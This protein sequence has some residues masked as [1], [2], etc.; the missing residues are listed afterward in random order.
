M[1]SSMSDTTRI[2]DFD[3]HYY[4]SED[5]FTRH[6]DK[7]LRSRG[8]RWAEVDGRRQILIGGKVN[9]YIAEPHVRSGGEARCA[10]PLV[11]RQSRAAVDHRGVR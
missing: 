9:S 1:L 3:N 8:V 2:F 6:Q 10:L 11:S 7:G 5:A 4:E